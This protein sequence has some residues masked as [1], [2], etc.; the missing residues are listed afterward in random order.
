MILV[1][2]SWKKPEYKELLTYILREDARDPEKERDFTWT[3]N[4]NG[5]SP[6]EWINE[7]KINDSHVRRIRANAVRI[8]HTVLSFAPEDSHL[9]SK[10]VL[11]DLSREYCDQKNPNGMFVCVPHFDGEHIHIHVMESAFE[12]RS[13]ASMRQSRDEFKQMKIRFQDYQRENHPKISHSIVEHDRSVKKPTHSR[14]D[15]ADFVRSVQQISPS[16]E[17]F[18]Q[19]LKSNGLQPYWRGGNLYGIE[20]QGRKY[21]FKTLG[22]DVSKIKTKSDSR[23]EALRKIRGPRNRGMER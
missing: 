4:L 3:H 8:Q 7:Y 6:E 21:R 22:V 13:G 14:T 19:E 9:L 16:Q 15:I 5:E 12:L 10:K 17:L 2:K 11:M 20:Y 1:S 23:L 18:V